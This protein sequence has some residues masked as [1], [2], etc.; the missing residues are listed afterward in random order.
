MRVMHV[1]C[2]C[3][4]VPGVDRDPHCILHSGLPPFGTVGDLLPKTS[5]QIGPGASKKADRVRE[6]TDIS[7]IPHAAFFFYLSS[8]LLTSTVLHLI[9]QTLIS[10]NIVYSLQLNEISALL[11][12]A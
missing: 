8:I 10:N 9:S 1:C 11:C 2:V 4:S 7:Y 5:R 6:V 3:C 12:Q